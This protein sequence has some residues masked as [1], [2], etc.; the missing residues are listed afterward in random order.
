M[1]S[2]WRSEKPSREPR[3]SLAPS[4]AVGVVELAEEMF[5]SARPT[6]FAGRP[7]LAPCPEHLV[8]H[9]IAHG[10]DWSPYPRY[11]WLIDV[12]KVLRR[13][14]GSFDWD[15][16][17][18]S[19]LRY[20]F[21]YM[22]GAALQE[23]REKAGID[24]PDVVLRRLRRPLAVLERLEARTRLS[25]TSARSIPGE[26]LLALQ[27]IRRQSQRDLQ[28]PLLGAISAL[29]QS[30]LGSFSGSRAFILNDREEPITHLQGWSA[31][32]P[33]GRWTDGKLVSCALNAPDGTRPT[34]LTLRGNPLHTAPPRHTLSRCPPAGAGWGP[35]GGE[36]PAWAPMRR[37]SG[38]RPRS[39][40]RARPFFASG[41]AGLH[42]R[43]RPA[44]T[45]IPAPSA[46]LSSICPS[47]RRRA[48]SSKRRST[49][50]AAA[51]TTTCCGMAGRNPSLSDPGLM[52]RPPCFAGARCATLRRSWSCA[53]RSHAPPAVRKTSAR[54]W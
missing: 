1:A 38:C 11:D 4:A 32:E 39:G 30:M 44:S 45:A 34:S 53:S 54:G 8:F 15:K 16:L 25:S 22:V 6:A 12:I 20:R 17:A 43:S 29:A 37:R 28:R 7:C 33:G 14:A 19:A 3:S 50:Q 21:G 24:V 9:A 47:I 40:E 18:A 26:F 10:F 46:F 5:A 49:F 42:R 51:P 52:A 41:S 48:M 31:P 36:S 27:G 2:R 13:T 23:G 35:C